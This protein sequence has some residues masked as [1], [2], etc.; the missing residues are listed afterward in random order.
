[1]KNIFVTLLQSKSRFKYIN[2]YNI[3]KNINKYKN[4][5]LNTFVRP[6]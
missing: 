2:I 5:D 4:L 1:M 3:Y 6:C